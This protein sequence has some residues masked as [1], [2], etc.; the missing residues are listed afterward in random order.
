MAAPRRRRGAAG[1]L[2][3]IAAVVALV[4]VGGLTARYVVDRVRR[5]VSSAVDSARSGVD[6][7]IGDVVGGPCD[8]LT[9][10]QAEAVLGESRVVGLGTVAAAARPALDDRVLPD[11]PTCWVGAA[12]G[13]VARVARLDTADAAE[14]AGV[15]DAEAAKAR[16]GPRPYHAGGVRGFRGQA[17]CT[18][19]NTAGS[20]GILARRGDRLV[21]ASVTPDLTKAVGGGSAGNSSN[22]GG[23]D[24]VADRIAA[25]SCRT[26]RALADGALR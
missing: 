25:D 8:F 16:R 15:F 23:L 4:V 20:A 10:A 14:A 9:E 11:A 3:A 1:C 22:P 24:R 26:A 5:E 13:R 2:V 19:I 17:F 12:S 18:T 6:D 7:A 21:Y